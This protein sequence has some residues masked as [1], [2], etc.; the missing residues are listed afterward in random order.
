M[1]SLVRGALAL[2]R[3]AFGLAI[4]L[5]EVASSVFRVLGA[6]H[7][8]TCSSFG[9]VRGLFSMVRFTQNAVRGRQ[10]LRFD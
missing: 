6:A 10:A 8:D 2:V 9:H 5:Q 4:G 1:I 7:G 3:S